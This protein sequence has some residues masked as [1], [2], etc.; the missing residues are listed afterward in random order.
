MLASDQPP[1]PAKEIRALR[2][3]AVS[4]RLR[5]ATEP[6]EDLAAIVR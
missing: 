3:W 4:D 2:T 1:Y 6:P 5:G